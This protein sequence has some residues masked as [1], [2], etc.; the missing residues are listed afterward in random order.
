MCKYPYCKEI[1]ELC[2]ANH[3]IIGKKEYHSVCA[4][5][6][7]AKEEIKK[8]YAER[9]SSTVVFSQLQKII[10][11]IVDI[12]DVS[13]EYFYFAL[14]YAINHQITINY[15]A[16]LYYII[17]NSDIKTAYKKFTQKKLNKEVK[18]E[19]IESKEITFTI[20]PPKQTGWGIFGG[21]G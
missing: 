19:P 13:P 9:V 7:K 5:K 15:P 6:M 4:K 20:D 14:R 21:T 16:S 18:S 8:L 3:I 10:H 1:E 11:N 2:D 12:K 17:D